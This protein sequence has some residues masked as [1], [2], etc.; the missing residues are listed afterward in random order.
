MSLLRNADSS[1]E[2]SEIVGGTVMAR[3]DNFG[4]HGGPK[5][6]RSLDARFDRIE[7]YIAGG[8]SFPK[9]DSKLRLCFCR[10]QSSS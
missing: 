4:A 8:N 5:L 3:S 7:T 10:Q 6:E 2:F 1:H 9:V